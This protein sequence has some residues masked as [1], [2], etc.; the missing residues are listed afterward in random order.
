MPYQQ[1]CP[2]VFRSIHRAVSGL[3]YSVDGTGPYVVV[4]STVVLT[5]LVRSI[6]SVP[7]SFPIVFRTTSRLGRC[8]NLSP[9][10]RVEEQERKR[11][12]REISLLKST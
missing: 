5:V 6:V 11:M 1:I 10:N 12:M 8:E 2:R 3:S 9:I 4:S 7:L